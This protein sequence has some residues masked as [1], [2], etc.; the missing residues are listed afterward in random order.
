MI[1]IPEH[2]HI[3]VVFLLYLCFILFKMGFEILVRSLR[4]AE[5]ELDQLSVTP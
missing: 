2:L 5:N 1:P 3:A 4:K